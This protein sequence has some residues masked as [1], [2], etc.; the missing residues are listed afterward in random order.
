MVT[1]DDMTQVAE[2]VDP[3]PH[4]MSFTEAVS[5]Q[6]SVAGGVTG[7]TGYPRSTVEEPKKELPGPQDD[8]AYKRIKAITEAKIR[9]DARNAKMTK[10]CKSKNKPRDKQKVKAA[11]KSKKRNRG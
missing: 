1:H 4:V 7:E 10:C 6:E 2:P 8:P 3:K 11:K 5:A 9:R